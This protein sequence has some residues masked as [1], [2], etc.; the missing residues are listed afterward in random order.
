MGQLLIE[1]LRPDGEPLQLVDL[2]LDYLGELGYPLA[3]ANR[4]SRVEATPKVSKAGN[5]FFDYSQTVV[6]PH[7]LETRL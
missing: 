7:G 2:G 4:P 3:Q 6:L 1:Y 5:T